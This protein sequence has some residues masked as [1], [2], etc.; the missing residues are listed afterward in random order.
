MFLGFEK[1]YQST[2]IHQGTPQ[3][4][5]QGNPQGKPQGDHSGTVCETVHLQHTVHVVEHCI[6]SAVFGSKTTSTFYY[7]YFV[8]QTTYSFMV[9]CETQNNFDFIVICE[10]NNMYSYGYF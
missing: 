5:P 2:G 10:Q 6:Q 4:N 7:C 3:G 9:I 8:R 1:H